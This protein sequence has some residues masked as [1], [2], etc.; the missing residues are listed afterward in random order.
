M[1]LNLLGRNASIIGRARYILGNRYYTRSLRV[2]L[3]VL[4]LCL[5]VATPLLMAQSGLM[6][7][8]IPVG[9]LIG[10]AGFVLVYYQ[11]EWALLIAV[12]LSVIVHDGIST[13]TET[14][15]TFT[16]VVLLVT[17]AVWLFK[18]L[19]VER[20]FNLRPTPSNLPGMLFIAAVVFSTFWS[21]NYVEHDVSWLFADKTVPRITSA[22]ALILAMLTFF[23]F[24]NLVTTVRAM[25]IFVWWFI[26]MGT[27]FVILHLTTGAVPPPLNDRGQL[28]AWVS[29]LALGQF[30]FNG[31]LSRRLRM[32]LVGVS[33]LP[34]SI[35]LSGLS[36]LSGWLPHMVGMGLILSLRSRKWLLL[37]LLAGVLYVANN[38]GFLSGRINSENSES[39]ETRTKAWGRVLD[40]T[41]GHL[42]FGTGPAGYH[43]YF[44]I[45]YKS[46]LFQLSHNNYIDILAQTGLVGFTLYIWF[47]AG[48][49][50]MA[51]RTFKNAPP[52]GFRRGLAA[53]LLIAYPVTIL[54][55]MLGDWVTPFTYTQGLVGIDY[56]IWHWML[57][58]L[59][60]ALYYESRSLPRIEPDAAYAPHS[61][62]RSIGA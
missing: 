39:G 55:M 3:I 34:F 27:V 41:R 23:M 30:L 4:C 8:L 19:M 6:I 54:S 60:V 22:L 24:A 52:N 58:G 49:G 50:V 44:S 7:G 12:G 47:W 20:S 11:L 10:V 42:L 59:T 16:F 9:A 35:T 18:R 21:A 1:L 48:M 29:I 40:V 61:I 26:A 46:Q 43:Y 51:W 17:F 36:W 37:L 62:L 38:Q 33:V 25:R 31:S 32:V 14:K 15:I 45:L 57:A 56:T 28:Y 53:S 2:G 13:G 5:T